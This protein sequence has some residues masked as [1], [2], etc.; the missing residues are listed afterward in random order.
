V[1]DLVDDHDS[2]IGSS[3]IRRCL[4]NGLLHRAVAVLVVRSNG[5]FVLQQRS[6]RDLWQPGLWTISSTG[7]VKKGEEY[8]AAA[9]RELG[10][11]LGFEGPLTRASKHLI[12][13]ISGKGLTEYEWVSL[14]ICR[15]D[16]PCTIDPVE[17]EAVR[18][19]TG[20]ELRGMLDEGPLTPD[21]KLILTDYM[22][23]IS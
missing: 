9:L 20:S 7:H 5:R 14:F 11:E 3:T 2:V 13:P 12:P 22:N 8:K 4:E 19:V 6:K 15:S 21:A 23:H 1:V 17:L 18:E 10:E 16:S